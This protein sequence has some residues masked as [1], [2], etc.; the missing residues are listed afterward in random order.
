MLGM[1]ELIGEPE[2]TFVLRA[3]PALVGNPLIPALHGGAVAAFLEA[4][5]AIALTRALGLK[6]IPKPISINVGFFASGQ[7]ADVM[8]RPVVKRVGRRIAVVH[9]EAWQEEGTVLICSAQCDFKL[10][11]CL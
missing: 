9:S 3:R 7:L 11:P 6:N 5:S 4:A 10:Q 2:P 1:E 8:T